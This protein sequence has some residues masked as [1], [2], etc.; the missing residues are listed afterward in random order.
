MLRNRTKFPLIKSPRLAAVVV[1]KKILGIMIWIVSAFGVLQAGVGVTGASATSLKPIDRTALQ[2]IL[3]TTVKELMVP[4]A[5]VLLRTAQGEFIVSYGTTEL[6][7]AIPPRADTHFRIASNTKTMTAAVIMLLAQEGKLG[8]HNPVSKYV[9]D[10]PN[11]DNITIAE[12]LKM[13]SGL[14]NYTDA[15]ELATS[16]DHDPAKA[17]TAAEVLSIAFKH[18]P[19]FPPGQAYQYCNTNYVLLG[20]IAEKV[21]AKPLANIFQT[22]LF[23]PLGM[24]GT[25]LPAN[26]SNTLPKPYAHGYLYGSSSYA[27][28]DMPY[29]A[30]LRAEAKAGTLKPNDDTDQN[31]SYASA[32]GGVISTADD[33]ASWIR[34][35]IGGKLL[36][37]GNQRRWFESIG[38]EDPSKPDGQKYGYGIAQIS[39]G[40]N[41][42]Y[43]HGGE[44]P[45]YN[46]F[47]GYD[48]INDVT[49]IVWANLPLSVDGPLP[50]N[51]IMLKVL[52]QIYVESPL[53]QR[54]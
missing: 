10:V 3:D 5:M 46:S 29:P 52:D 1:P 18:P 27:V 47:M 9:P 19:L 40:P 50:A 39:F 21:E 41:R 13:R 53:K 34:A 26:T 51:T 8:I 30:D 16:L 54:Q 20:L 43:F 28:A 23:G 15:P 38:P 37:A 44:M 24:K 25:M 22:R 36:N 33:L 2:N 31:P 49:L 14:Y 11:G 35:L 4:G 7:V 48:P 32:A 12:L 45:G 6:G 42:L 17:W